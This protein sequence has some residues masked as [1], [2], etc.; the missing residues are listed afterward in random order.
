[1]GKIVK[2]KE[3]GTTKPTKPKPPAEL[4]PVSQLF[5]EHVMRIGPVLDA[6]RQWLH[7]MD[8]GIEAGEASFHLMAVISREIF[9]FAHKIDLLAVTHKLL[10]T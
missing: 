4:N 9:V 8:Q 2:R 6:Q 5:L 10:E 1:M 3:L 7:E